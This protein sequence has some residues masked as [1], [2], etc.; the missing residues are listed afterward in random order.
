MAGL[1]DSFGDFAT[2]AAGQ[3]LLSALG[4]GL[5]GARR[6]Q[7]LNAVGSGLLGGLQGYNQAQD[8]QMQQ[9]RFDQ[10]GKLFDAQ[11]QNYQAE[12]DARKAATLKQQQIATALGHAFSPVAPIDAN[13]ASG[14]TGPRPEALGVVGQ[15]RPVDYQGLIAQGVPEA[16]VKALAEAPNYGRS[17]VARTIKGVGQDGKE[18]EYQV[19]EYGS[20]V[21]DGLAQY[22]APIMQDLGGKVAALDAYS[23]KPIVQLGKTMTPDGQAS[24]AVAWFNA[25]TGRDR[26]TADLSKPEFK[27]GQWVTPPRDMKPGEVR[28]ISGGQGVK[29]ANDVLAMIKQAREILPNSTGSY[30]GMLYDQGARI[31]GKATDGAM[32]SAKLKALEGSLIAKMPKMSGPQSDADARRYE[33][34]VGQI[35]DPTIPSAQKVAALDVVEEIQTRYASGQGGQPT[36]PV[37]LPNSIGGAPTLSNW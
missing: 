35:G 8:Q 30:G 28:A 37:R 32:A 17:K 18:Y 22:R 11:M 34:A 5:A 12:A 1:L 27:D 16:T 6:G 9:K 3:G 23:L 20:R 7:P 29:D 4:A 10:Q 2:S 15:R 21:G 31:F 24:N 36:A 26:L 19:D 14:I 13:A 25:K 33:Q